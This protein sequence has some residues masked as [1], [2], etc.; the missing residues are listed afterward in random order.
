MDYRQMQ[1]LILLKTNILKIYKKKAII[2]ITNWIK[3]SRIYNKFATLKNNEK[4]A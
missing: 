2:K 1:I 3:I 4:E